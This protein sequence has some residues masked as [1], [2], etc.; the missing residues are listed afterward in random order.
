MKGFDSKA[1]R[2]LAMM[3]KEHYKG[4][5]PSWQTKSP[6]L[7]MIIKK[8]YKGIP[9]YPTKSPLHF[10]AQYGMIYLFKKTKV[11]NLAPCDEKGRSPLH[12]AAEF[13]QLSVVKFI[14][15]AVEDRNPGDFGGVT[16]LHLAAKNNHMLVVL[17]IIDQ[18]QDKNP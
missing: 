8:N 6:I 12:Y 14:I 1:V 13:G 11:T 2:T 17:L 7:A 16:P 18:I 15:N 4:T 10:A 3:I 5:M 9:C